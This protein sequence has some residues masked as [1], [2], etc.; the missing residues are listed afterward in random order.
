MCWLWHCL[1]KCLIV[2]CSAVCWKE[3]SGSLSRGPGLRSPESREFPR[4]GHGLA[5]GLLRN[6]MMRS[7]SPS[8]GELQGE[9]GIG[10]GRW[11]L[12]TLDGSTMETADNRENE[13]AFG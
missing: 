3:S 4:P 5:Q 11:H 7:S 6:C 1:C 12:V 10:G 13:A 2:K 8:P 9:P